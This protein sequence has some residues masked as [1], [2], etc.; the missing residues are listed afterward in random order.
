M[1]NNSS[2]SELEKLPKIKRVKTDPK[3][4]KAKTTAKQ[5][6]NTYIKKN[7]SVA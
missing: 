7:G 3:T 2:E 1:N 6:A 5:I 4:V